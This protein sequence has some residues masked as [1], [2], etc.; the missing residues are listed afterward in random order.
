MEGSLRDLR[1]NKGSEP[2][3]NFLLGTLSDFHEFL[4]WITEETGML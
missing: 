3:K 2:P 1:I 4:R